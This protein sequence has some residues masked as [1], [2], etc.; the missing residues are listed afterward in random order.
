MMLIPELKVLATR[1]KNIHPEI[2]GYPNIEIV[3]NNEILLKE[4]KNLERRIVTTF[5]NNLNNTEITFEMRQ[6]EP[7]EIKRMPSKG[8]MFAEMK[9]KCPPLDMLC[10]RIELEMA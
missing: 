1:M 7:E 2:K 4:V 10:K 6:A 9:E 5:R 8:E 3:I